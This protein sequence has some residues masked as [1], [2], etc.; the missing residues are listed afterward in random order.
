[1]IHMGNFHPIMD[2]VYIGTGHAKTT[3]VANIGDTTITIDDTTEFND[4]GYIYLGG[5]TISYTSIDDNTGIISGIPATGTGSITAIHAINSEVWQNTQPGEPRYFTI[6][7]GEV[8]FDV[9]IS[10]AY[11]GKKIRIRFLVQL[12]NISSMNDS[13][14]VP[15]Y[16]ALHDYIAYKIETRRK[17]FDI[18][19]N[20]KNEF[21]I[22]VMAAMKLYQSVVMQP[23]RYHRF[24]NTLNVGFAYNNDN[25][26]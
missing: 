14:E 3:A 21:K 20:H 17:N 4:S 12:P 26:P 13:V 19:A 22:K 5:D 15:F 1:M 16:K 23:Y 2:N 9:P 8:K 24:N 6:F 10:I 25:Q 7:N 11:S 18:A